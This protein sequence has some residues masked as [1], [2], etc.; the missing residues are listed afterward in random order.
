MTKD[1]AL[2]MAIEVLETI[3]GWLKTRGYTGLMPKE[4]Q[5]IEACKAAISDETVTLPD[6]E[7]EL[8]LQRNSLSLT[9]PE[10]MGDSNMVDKE[11]LINF[12][13]AYHKAL[14]VANTLPDGWVAVPVEPTDEMIKAATYNTN[15]DWELDHSSTI[16]NYKAM[17][18]AAPTLNEVN[19]G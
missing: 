15:L 16:G 13:N 1:E 14:S 8:L 6:D 2:K 18:Q 11:D 19:H 5:A 12:A 10:W 7:L 9:S 3:D 17:L 4:K